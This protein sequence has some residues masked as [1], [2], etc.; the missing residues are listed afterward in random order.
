MQTIYV[1]SG[2]GTDHRVFE[3]IDLSGFNIVHVKWLVPR[4][5]EAFES[6]VFR[7][8]DHYNIPK[9]G[10]IVMGVSFG[11]ICIS[12]LS[13]YYD[14]SKTILISSAKTRDELPK[15]LSVSKFLSLHKFLPAAAN[16][17]AS[18]KIAHWL[19]GVDQVEDKAL[20]DQILKD[21]SPDFLRWAIDKIVN[22]ENKTVPV[23]CLHIHG[24][25]DHIIPIQHVDYTIRIRGGGHFMIWT[26]AAEISFS[27]RNFLL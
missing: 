4:Q 18:L 14:F 7:L 15:L 10:A 23:N 11:G 13:K 5:E 22:W 24:D 21:T 25:K 1:F 8:A 17:K 16:S 27:I 2:L 6:Y 9:Q 3:R 20:L 26:K 19:F 12:E